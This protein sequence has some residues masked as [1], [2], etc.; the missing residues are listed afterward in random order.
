MKPNGD[1]MR[2]EDKLTAYIT[3]YVKLAGA[4]NRDE[5]F[6][7]FE[8]IQFLFPQWV[9]ITCPVMHPQFSYVSKNYTQ[10]FPGKNQQSIN[11]SIAQFFNMVH[12]ADHTYLQNCFNHVHEHLESIDP[13]LHFQYRQVFHYR[14][15]K[16]HL[17]CIYVHDEK[18]VLNLKDSG[19]LYYAF[20]KD[21]TYEKA[22]TGV[23]VEL[24]K[25]DHTIS[26]I[27]QYKPA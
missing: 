19:N 27:S 20:L 16:N 18:A 10:I 9:I 12:A 11:Q 6:D 15:Q 23:K 1:L 8:K 26:K 24:F 25:H 21:I 7:L 4:E 3:K 17:Q 13:E 5:V 22:F 14:L 2:M